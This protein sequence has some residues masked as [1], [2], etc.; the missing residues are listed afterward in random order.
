M[1]SEFSTPLF[2]SSQFAPCGWFPNAYVGN[3]KEASATINQ[4]LNQLGKKAV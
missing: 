3:A 4:P 2:F 1:G